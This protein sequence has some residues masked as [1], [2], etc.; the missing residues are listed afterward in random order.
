MPCTRGVGRH[1]SGHQAPNDD[2]TWAHVSLTVHVVVYV[3]DGVDQV[4][5]VNASVVQNILNDDTA[6]GRSSERHSENMWTSCLSKYD[7]VAR[8]VLSWLRLPDGFFCK[9]HRG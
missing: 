8:L 2:S 4:S 3:K 7:V 9:R 1:S 6:A 5:P